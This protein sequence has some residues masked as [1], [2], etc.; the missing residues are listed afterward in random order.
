MGDRNPSTRRNR[1]II[2]NLLAQIQSHRDHERVAG[3]FSHTAPPPPNTLVRT[4]WFPSD[5]VCLADCG[6]I[7]VFVCFD[8]YETKSVL[9]SS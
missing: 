8:C 3:G 2:S 9:Q 5:A 6:M 7:Y 4:G 1:N